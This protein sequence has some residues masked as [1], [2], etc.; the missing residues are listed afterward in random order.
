MTW[1]NN[2]IIY[3]NIIIKHIEMFPLIFFTVILIDA[4]NGESHITT[5]VM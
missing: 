5:V 2:T 3:N 1:H 4:L